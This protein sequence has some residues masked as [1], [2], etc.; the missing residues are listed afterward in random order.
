MDFRRLIGSLA[1]ILCVCAGVLGTVFLLMAL[2]YPDVDRESNM[3]GL[4]FWDT[5]DE[6]TLEDRSALLNYIERTGRLPQILP[7]W[8]MDN[9]MCSLTV[10]KYAVVFTGI[11]L[12]HTSAW[13]L[14]SDRAKYK[15]TNTPCVECPLNATKLATVWDKTTRYDSDGRLPAGVKESFQN[16]VR[17]F[18]FEHDQV[19]LM[20]LLWEDTDYWDEIKAAGKD[21]NSHVALWARGKVIHF[22]HRKPSV[23]PLYRESVDDLFADGK[24]QPV[25]IARVHAKGRRAGLRLPATDREMAFCQNVMPYTT[26]Y[27]AVKFPRKFFLVPPRYAERLDALVERTVLHRTRN[28]YD[29]YPRF[30]ATEE[31]CGS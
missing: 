25:W 13:K 28:G 22:I 6:L 31:A 19:Y 23:D 9:A 3:E 27:W 17:D 24:L 8:E 14:R 2:H 5:V 12:A 30:A 26:L 4:A 20:G 18:P 16:E 15:G 21:V 10:V 29:M 1:S 7:W 11:K